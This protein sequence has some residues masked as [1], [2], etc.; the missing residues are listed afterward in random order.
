ML[1]F[2]QLSHPIFVELATDLPGQDILQEQKS[3]AQEQRGAECLMA[4]FGTIT[5]GDLV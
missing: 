4:P 2:L 1:H 5:E 3:P